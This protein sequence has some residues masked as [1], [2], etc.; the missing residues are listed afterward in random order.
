METREERV[1]RATRGLAS[2]EEDEGSLKMNDETTERCLSGGFWLPAPG[3][4]VVEEGVD[5][6]VVD[7]L[8][9]ER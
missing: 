2:C 3:F 7:M 9:N 6:M 5:D 1:K 8:D 4:G